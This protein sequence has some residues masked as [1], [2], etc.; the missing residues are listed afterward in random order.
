MRELGLSAEVRFA[1]YNQVFQE[2][3]DPGGLLAR[4]ISGVN[5][6]LVRFDDWPA[7]QA[8]GFVDAVR[9]AAGRMA[10]P[11]IVVLCPGAAQCD[12]EVRQ[13]VAGL[14]SVYLLTAARIAALYPVTEVH[15]P[16]GDQLGRIPYTPLYFVA[17]ATALARQ[18]HAIQAPPFKAIALDC[19][20]TL[21]A[22]ICGED[23]PE[24]VVLDPPRR[25]LQELADSLAL[26][27]HKWMYMPYEIGCILVREEKQ[28]RKAFCLTPKYLAHGKEEHGVAGGDLPWFSDYSYEL[29]R[30]FRA[31]KAWISIKEHGSK[32]YARIVQQNI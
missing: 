15:D 16:A 2:L 23:G 6:V 30:G 12:D 14:P 29:S 27:L 28:H 8:A 25:A 32:K 9:A 11:L 26:D 4:N 3:L 10:V 20:D 21:W 19:D 1:A 31:L 13:G 24:G 18:I 22:G 5:V 17:L 7:G